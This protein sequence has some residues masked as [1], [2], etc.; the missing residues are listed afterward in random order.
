MTIL[1]P[2]MTWPC[3]ISSVRTTL[4]PDLLCAVE[5]L[6]RI[7]VERSDSSRCKSIAARISRPPVQ[8]TSNL[9]EY[10]PSFAGR[11]PASSPS[12]P[13]VPKNLS[14]PGSTLEGN[15]A[16]PQAPMFHDDFQAPL[17]G[18]AGYLA[19]SGSRQVHSCR[20][21]GGGW[22]LCQ[23]VMFLFFSH[24]VR[25]LP[26]M[27]AH[28]RGHLCDLHTRLRGSTSSR[29]RDFPILRFS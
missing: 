10:S 16:C 24:R 28:D 5:H 7:P 6:K 17:A 29:D 4:H 23:R 21:R 14:I 8:A 26:A 2:S 27:S 20:E 1:T 12:F 15:D 25:L 13:V 11:I 3:C 9:R 22:A 18:L 19:S